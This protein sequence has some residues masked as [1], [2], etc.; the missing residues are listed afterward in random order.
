VAVGRLEANDISLQPDP[1]LL[2]GRMAHCTFEREGR[3]WYV[4]DGGSVNGTFVRRADTIERLFGRT[5]LHDGDVVCVLAFVTV[6]DERLF[7][8]LAFHAESDPHATRAAP[9]VAKVS[10]SDRAACLVYDVHEARLLAVVGD[11]SHEVEVRAQVHELVRY[12]VERNAEIGGAPALCT[13]EELMRA[14][15]ND[16]PMHTREELAKLVWELRRKLEPLGAAN[17]VETERRRGYRLRT[18]LPGVVRS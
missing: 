5:P 3:Q 17:A 13:H 6:D 14:V 9:V 10:T 18:C 2:V 11:E 4:V 1:Q 7:F 15:W 12:M 8:E 16:E